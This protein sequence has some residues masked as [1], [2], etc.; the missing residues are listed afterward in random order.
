MPR[1]A[2]PTSGLSGQTDFASASVHFDGDIVG[3]EVLDAS[4]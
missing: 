1:R 2:T 3:I 4:T